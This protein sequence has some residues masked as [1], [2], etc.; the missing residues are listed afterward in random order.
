MTEVQLLIHKIQR[1]NREADA[2]VEN[3]ILTYLLL[4][5]SHINIIALVVITMVFPI[6][7]MLCECIACYSLI[8]QAVYCMLQR[9]MRGRT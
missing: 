4:V 1:F 9:T 3:S 6:N 5:Y 8:L 7:C 2:T